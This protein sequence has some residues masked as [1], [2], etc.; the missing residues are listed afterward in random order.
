[1][2]A[3]GMSEEEILKAFPD[4]TRDDI[5]ECLRYATDRTREGRCP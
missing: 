5:R 4:L 1:M 2:A 3:D